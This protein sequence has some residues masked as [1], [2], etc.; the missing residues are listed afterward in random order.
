LSHE[1]GDENLGFLSESHGFIPRQPPLLQLPAS[2]DAWDAAA[3]ELPRLFRLQTIRETLDTLPTIGAAE[4]DLPDRY[5]WRASGLL[6]MLAQAYYRGNAAPPA[7]LPDCIV[8]P[9]EEVS[10]RLGRAQPF[11]AYADLIV[12]NWKVRDPTAADPM[13]VG[14]LDL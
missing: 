1:R 10:R 13:R 4:I 14:N 5:L 7:A 11:L 9:W 2:H 8:Q 12:H 3:E 6:S